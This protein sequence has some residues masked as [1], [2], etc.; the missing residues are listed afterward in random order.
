MMHPATEVGASKS[1]SGLGV[2]ATSDI[3]KGTVIWILD[4]FDRVISPAAMRAWPPA[5]RAVAERLGYVAPDGSWVVC[6]DH[7]RLMNHSCDPATVSV[8]SSLEIARRGLRCGDEV[9]CD[10]GTLNLTRALRCGCG[11]PECRG[12]VSAAEATRLCTMWDAWADE[13]FLAALAVPQPLLP[14][15]RGD[16][17]D[18]GI[19]AALAERRPVHLPSSRSLL[20]AAAT[21]TTGRERRPLDC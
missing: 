1:I 16:G 18:A 15:A 13:A 3:P 12:S 8:G 20:R 10:Y 19:L 14:F 17:V 9:T 21:R 2:F 7:G 11:V 6:W 4:R 5:V